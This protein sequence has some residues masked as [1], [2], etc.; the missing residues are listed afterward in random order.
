MLPELALADA[1]GPPTMHLKRTATATTSWRHRPASPPPVLVPSTRAT[2]RPRRRT[3]RP[4]GN[5]R[6][7]LFNGTLKDQAASTLALSCSNS[8][9]VMAPLSR[10]PL[11]DA[12]SSA[13]LLE[14]PATDL[15]YSFWACCMAF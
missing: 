8:A 10:R 11:A 13:A 9:W 5:G 12:I 4:Q 1:Q 2:R 7:H 6:L 3:C 14:D 15:T